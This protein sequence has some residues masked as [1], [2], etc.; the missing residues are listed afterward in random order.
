MEIRVTCKRYH[1]RND[2]V[3]LFAYGGVTWAVEAEAV[4]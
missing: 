3:S 1:I 2:V 4:V